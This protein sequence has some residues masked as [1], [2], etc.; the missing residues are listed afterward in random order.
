[1]S[2]SPQCPPQSDLTAHARNRLSPGQASELDDHLTRCSSCFDQYFKEQTD[3]SFPAVPGFRIVRELGRGRFG[4]VYKAWQLET[5]PR[6]V[7]IKIL[8]SLGDMEQHRF[9][10][11]C[12][13]LQH[14]DSPGVVHYLGAGSCGGMPYLVMDYVEGIPLDA[15]LPDASLDWKLGVLEA[16]CRAVAD[17]HDAGVVHRDLKPSNILVDAKG[18]PHVVDFG[19]CGVIRTEWSTWERMTITQAGDILG[20]LKYMSPEQ[21]WGRE[22]AGPIGK[23][24]DIWSLGILLYQ[25]VTN[26]EY[27]YSLAPTG[28]RPPH[29][30]LLERIRKELP[31]LPRL[32]HLPRGKD[33][34]LLLQRCLAWEPSRRLAS[35]RALADDIAR[36]RERT[37]V[38]T[39]PFGL[40]YRAQR[41]AIGIAIRSR[42]VFAAALI[43][44]VGAALWLGVFPVPV[45]WEAQARELARGG[46]AES[47]GHQDVRDSTVVVGISDTTPAAAVPWAKEHGEAGVTGNV[48]TWRGL[49]GRLMERFAEARPAAV[50][51]DYYFATPQDADPRLLEGIRALERRDI[52]VVLA[53]FRYSSSGMPT[54]TPVLTEGMG[55]RLRHGTIVA[56][57]QL[58]RPGQFVLALRRNGTAIPSVALTTL[59]AMIHPDARLEIDW[60]DRNTLE[61][62]YEELPQGRYLREE[63]SRSI[64][65]DRLPVDLVYSLREPRPPAEVGDLLACAT[66]PLSDPQAWRARTVAYEDILGCSDQDLAHAIRGK[67][68][69]VG[70][71]RTRPDGLPLD[72]HPVRFGQDV[73]TAVPG[74]YLL[75]D[76]ICGLLEGRYLRSA[77]PLP[78]GTLLTMLV[79]AAAGY[80]AAVALANS[81][82][83]ERVTARWVCPIT[84]LLGVGAFG[85]MW[86]AET[87]WG[88]HA[89]M[90]GFAFLVPMAGSFWV[91]SARNRFR[92]LERHRHELEGMHVKDESG[93]LTLDQRRASS[94]TA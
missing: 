52:P 56:R 36:Y 34:E 62:L 9:E 17:A 1:M 85:M 87:Y 88:V 60:P 73:V 32:S 65:R 42:L 94:S 83:G 77:F 84:L 11:E 91:E 21:A 23:R 51:W 12:A 8:T 28:G 10:R 86:A 2:P 39:R 93:T 47:L 63:D 38:R 50:I 49:H 45:Y 19:I 27:P 92:V 75:C 79:I 40:G 22:I 78:V 14:I 71:F 54:L 30:A 16:I 90:G 6:V 57:Q 4:V 29:E 15:R 7:A 82:L 64:R 70:D 20:T 81:S 89:A 24:S 41:L 72:A 26:G 66:L 46:P 74:C 69:L 37:P 80:A 3:T 44:A 33:L 61:L 31:R 25:V 68:V 43:A 67:I 35:A 55:Q 58:A 13:A 53:A 59:A 76:A 48:R 5:R 18:H